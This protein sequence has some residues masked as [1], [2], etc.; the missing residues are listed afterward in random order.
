MAP[1]REY[2]S[3]QQ[4]IDLSQRNWSMDEEMRDRFARDFNCSGDQLIRWDN[5]H[6]RL[7]EEGLTP[8]EATEKLMYEAK[9]EFAQ[10]GG[11][12]IPFGSRAQEAESELIDES[13]K[14]EAPEKEQGNGA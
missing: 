3:T 11:L 12:H 5:R 2:G 6:A 10:K 8:D 1:N 13:V 4:F 9:T 7:M 14:N